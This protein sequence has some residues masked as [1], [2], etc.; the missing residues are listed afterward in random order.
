MLGEARISRKQESPAQSGA[1]CVQTFRIRLARAACKGPQGHTS[2]SGNAGAK[3]LAARK[4]GHWRFRSIDDAVDGEPTIAAVRKAGYVSLVA[5]LCVVSLVGCGSDQPPAPPASPT[6]APVVVTDLP[7]TVDAVVGQKTEVVLPEN[8]STGY[9]WSTVPPLVKPGSA[10][11]VAVGESTYSPG[12][13]L[14]G[15]PGESHTTIIAQTPGTAVVVFRLSPPNQ[16]PDLK[17]I[18][19]LTVVVR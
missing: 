12:E 19:R 6:P 1:K 13:A 5:V 10:P 17:N 4:V 15:A 18:K 2:R 16:Q 9:T 14:P 8:V 11:V 7:A 3:Y